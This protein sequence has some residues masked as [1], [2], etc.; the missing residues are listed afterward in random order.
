[1]LNRWLGIGFLAAAIAAQAACGASQ[2]DASGRASGPGGAPGPMPP[3]NGD[4]TAPVHRAGSGTSGF[5]TGTSAENTGTMTG[6]GGGKLGP[7]EGGGRPSEPPPT[8]PACLEAMDTAAAEAVT[9]DGDPLTRSFYESADDSNSMGSPTLARELLRAH[10]SPDPATVRTYEFL[11]Y[12]RIRHPAAAAGHVAI[13][14]DAEVSQKDPSRVSLQIGVRAVDALK[15]RRPISLTL[16]LDASGSLA[17]VGIERERALVRALAKK[18]AKDDVLSVV[19]WNLEDS[20]LLSGHR[21]TGPNDATVLAVAEAIRPQGGSDLHAGLRAAYALAHE[22][23]DKT[24]LNRVMLVSDG[25]ANLGVVDRNVIAVEARDADKEGI[26]LA[27]VG[28]GPALGYADSLM[29]AVT[30]AGRGAYVYLDSAGEAAGLFDKRF[31]EIVGIAARDVQ[32]KLTVPY[33]FDIPDFFG[34]AYSTDPV[35]IDP[36]HLAPGG[37]MI[38]QQVIARCAYGFTD[39]LVSGDPLHV[40][41]TWDDPLTRQPHTDELTLDLN[42]LFVGAH[43]ALHK[44]EAIVGYAEALKLVGD[45]PPGQLALAHARVLE[46]LA[47]P[48]LAADPEL[49]EIAG[50]LPNHPLF[51]AVPK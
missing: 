43:A 23:F 36:Q 8:P 11:N 1:M 34:E 19:T 30:D 13:Y 40:L 10:Q 4:T 49:T 47:S 26:Y 51:P 31:D 24:W 39:P 45:D 25:G 16:A 9:T 21:V 27:G 48:E 6:A 32:V 20:V 50:L 42:D 46:L 44:G 38:F 15:V 41:V 35:A 37:E 28:L 18:L 33:Y 14:A 22:N 17:G 5:S 29:N 12:Y 7:D 3:S 2:D